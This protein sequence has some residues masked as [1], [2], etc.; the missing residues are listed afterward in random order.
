MAWSYQP[1]APVRYQWTDFSFAITLVL[2]NWKGLNWYK[3]RQSMASFFNKNSSNSVW[4]ASD[5]LHETYYQ[6]GWVVSVRI[7]GFIS[8]T[9]VKTRE[10]QS[11]GKVLEVKIHWWTCFFPP[12]IATASLV[13]AIRI[14]AAPVTTEVPCTSPLLSWPVARILDEE[15]T[16]VSWCCMFLFFCTVFPLAWYTLMPLES[17]L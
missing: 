10:D 9:R 6:Y 16:P 3:T 13:A 2:R 5:L 14:T 4:A 11:E 12:D 7:E 15:K 17:L 1:K 8:W